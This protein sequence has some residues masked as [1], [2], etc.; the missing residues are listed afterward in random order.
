MQLEA[1][2]QRQSQRVDA[3]LLRRVGDAHDPTDGGRVLRGM[4]PHIPRVALLEFKSVAR[5]FAK[6]DLYRL[7][8]LG[9]HWLARNPEHAPDD[10]LLV[11]VVPTLTDTLRDEVARCGVTLTQER[12][13]YH[14]ADVRGLQ[15]L[16]AEVDVVCEAEHDDH[17]RVFSHHPIQTEEVVEWLREHTDLSEDDVLPPEEVAKNEPYLRKLAQAIPARIRLEGL[18]PEERLV[19]LK[20]EER[21]VGLKPEEVLPRFKPEE[22]LVGL[23]PE[24]RLVGLKPEERLVGLKPEERL[25]DLAPS[26][27]VLALPDELLRALSPDYIATLP[28]DVQAIVRARLAR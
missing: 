3:L 13:G 28:D 2:L 8:A 6:G 24:E 7:V 10:L 11:L 17:L 19:G 12:D 25:T 4:W 18:K 9:W 16:L 26:Q 27:A 15:L 14:L 21:L 20:P 1:L 23:K 22:R 5:L